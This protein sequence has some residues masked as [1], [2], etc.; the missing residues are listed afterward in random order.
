MYS[1][2]FKNKFIFFLKINFLFFFSMAR[3]KLY[4][5]MS[6]CKKKCLT[7]KNDITFNQ[8]FALVMFG[9]SGGSFHIW[10]RFFF[11][12]SGK[13]FVFLVESILFAY[14]QVIQVYDSL[15]LDR[16]R[17][18]LEFCGGLITWKKFFKEFPKNCL[19]ISIKDC[20]CA[21]F[22]RN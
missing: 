3:S 6:L 4:I 9:W 22:L 5:K 17:M 11:L 16:A 10:N 2:F 15:I 21:L 7:L 18:D 1:Q 12:I 13:E 20:L 19:K 8:F 14:D